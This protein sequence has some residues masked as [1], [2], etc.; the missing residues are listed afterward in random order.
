MLML[1]V[2]EREMCHSTKQFKLVRIIV[3]ER[4][5]GLDYLINLYSLG[6]QLGMV[7]VFI[8][9]NPPAT[10]KIGVVEENETQW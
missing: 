6:M 7:T 5:Q 4:N 3:R 2:A 1:E 8:S 9:L 10:S